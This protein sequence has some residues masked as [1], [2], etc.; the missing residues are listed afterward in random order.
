MQLNAGPEPGHRVAEILS[1]SAIKS[2]LANESREFKTCDTLI[3]YTSI[4]Q[5]TSI[6]LLNGEKC[7]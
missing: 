2:S 3:R 4:I 6:T 5:Y 1:A 7:E